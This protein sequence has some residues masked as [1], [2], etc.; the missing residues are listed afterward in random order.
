[1]MCRPGHVARGRVCPIRPKGGVCAD[2]AK[3]CVN[4]DRRE[5]SRTPLA[6]SALAGGRRRTDDARLAYVAV[7]MYGLASRL[8]ENIP[9]WRGN[10]RLEE[11]GEGEGCPRKKRV[12][13]RRELPDDAIGEDGAGPADSSQQRF[14]QEGVSGS[15]T[16]TSNKKHSSVSQLLTGSS[17]YGNARQTRRLS[18]LRSTGVRLRQ[19]IGRQTRPSRA[20]Q[21]AVVCGLARA[22]IAVARPKL[23]GRAGFRVS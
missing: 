4:R 20:E 11:R 19:Q 22:R 21:T 14:P 23:H 15:S 1:M 7:C 3:R 9:G 10:S 2:D 18:D 17:G 8:G 5:G 6:G 12:R 13:S 16:A